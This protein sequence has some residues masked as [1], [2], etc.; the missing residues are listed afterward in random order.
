MCTPFASG[1]LPPG[2]P[3][4]NADVCTGC[5]HGT[6][7]SNNR[8]RGEFS[9][10]KQ[11]RT[12]WSSLVLGGLVLALALVWG[13]SAYASTRIDATIT[14]IELEV[15]H[16]A[17]VTG[18]ASGKSLCY[19]LPALDIWLQNRQART[20]FLF[21]TKALAQDQKRELAGLLSKVME[22]SG[23]VCGGI[24]IYDGDTPAS[25]RKLISENSNFVF[26]N[27]DMLHLGIMPH[28]TRWANF[29][30]NLRLVVI[31]EV[32]LYR[33]IFG[34]HFTNVIRRLKRIASFYGADP[35]FICTSATLANTQEFITRLIEE[36][37]FVIDK[38]SSP[39]GRKV[40]ALYNPPLINSELSIRRSSM[41][42]TI[43]LGFLLTLA[44]W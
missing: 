31:D 20:M 2:N 11:R 29:F 38:D 37:V 22:E 42:E 34:S 14:G 39:Q 16:L 5:V 33:G 35:Q 10:T 24:G 7:H 21:P 40:Y 3:G 18:V 4:P 43:S 25:Q 27:P 9:V 36:D 44:D 26:T 15:K 28:H 23:A 19:Q 41:L 30:A 6:L 13:F 32:H 12:T 8:R 1:Y 17:I